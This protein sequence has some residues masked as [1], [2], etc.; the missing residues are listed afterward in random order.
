MSRK[1][2]DWRYKVTII[3]PK[4]SECFA[5]L[6]IVH[7]RVLTG[8]ITPGR[9][10]PYHEGVHGPL[11]ATLRRLSFTSLRRKRDAAPVVALQHLTHRIL[12]FIQIQISIQCYNPVTSSDHG[13]DP[14]FYTLPD[15]EPVKDFQHVT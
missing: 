9:L 1:S 14:V 4:L 2:G 13:G 10:R 3:P 12:R 5:E 8:E 7:L 15:W 6:C 11:N